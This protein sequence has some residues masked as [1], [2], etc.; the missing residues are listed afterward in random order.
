MSSALCELRNAG[1]AFLQQQMRQINPHQKV[2][3]TSNGVSHDK[4]DAFLRSVFAIFKGL[5]LLCVIN[6]VFAVGHN[7]SVLIHTV[8]GWSPSL[9][10]Y[11]ESLLIKV[12]GLSENEYGPCEVVLDNRK[13]S[14]SRWRKLMADGT[15]HSA[16]SI[17][18]PDFEADAPEYASISYPFMHTLLGFRKILVRNNKIDQYGGI[19][20]I[21]DFR[22]YTVGMGRFWA[23]YYVFEQAKVPLVTGETLDELFPMLDKGRYDF[24]PLSILEVDDL[25]ENLEQKNR[26]SVLENVYVFYPLPLNFVI[27]KKHPELMS[28]LRY[29][30]DAYFST[31]KKP[32]TEPS[33]YDQLFDVEKT[34]R[35]MKGITFLLKNPGLSDEVNSRLTEYFINNFC[36][37]GMRCVEG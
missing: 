9:Q 19:S 33:F 36:H 10:R 11:Q 21:V 23:D 30:F 16:F 1:S 5:L 27:S 37:N 15:V 2:G 35:R 31:S 24:L 13:M 34:L 14:K 20:D 25:L 28:R 4:F 8:G 3:K 22:K 12:L 32:V 7:H 29:G 17:E 18:T 26:I 6:P